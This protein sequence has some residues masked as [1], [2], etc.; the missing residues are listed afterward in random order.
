MKTHHV[1][2]IFL[3]VVISTACGNKSS[4][5][6]VNFDSEEEWIEVTEEVEEE[7][8]NCFGSGTINSN[9]SECGGYGY[10]TH[11]HWLQNTLPF[12]DTA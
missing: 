9:C 11:Y 1:I 8:P 12:R 2:I 3:F 10:K 7:C 4:N 6:Q 5:N